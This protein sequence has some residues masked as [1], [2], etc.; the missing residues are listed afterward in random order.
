[1]N[2]P[3]ATLRAL[4]G[5]KE[6]ESFADVLDKFYSLG[7]QDTKPYM[8]EA[9]VCKAYCLKPTKLKRLENAK[10][11]LF[12]MQLGD[13][14]KLPPPTSSALLQ[15]ACSIIEI[16]IILSEM[17]CISDKGMYIKKYY[18]YSSNMT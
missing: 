3:D 17:F 8:P 16:L 10:F 6:K 18:E 7:E 11:Y 5:E 12:K 9:F 14:E 4:A 15:H 13:P 1:M 2:F